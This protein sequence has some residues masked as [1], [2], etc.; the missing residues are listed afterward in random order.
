TTPTSSLIPS[1]FVQSVTFPATVTGGGGPA[2]AG[3]VTFIEGRTCAAPG[4]T[5]AGPTTVNASGQASFS[6]SALTASGSPHTI[7]ACYGGSGNLNACSG[8]VSQAVNKA[9]LTTT[10]AYH[11]KPSK[12]GQSGTFTA[13]VTGGG[14]PATAGSVTFI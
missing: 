2:A 8:S 3:T 4:T 5:L 7:V 9:A 11:P 13:T 14:S 10:V 1:T 12:Y 6:T